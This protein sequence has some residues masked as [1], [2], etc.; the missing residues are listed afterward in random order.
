MK[1]TVWFIIS[2]VCLTTGTMADTWY[3]ATNSVT[4]GPGTA[5]A[6]AFWTIQGGVDAASGG[7]TVLV[8]NG[9][10]NAGGG[11]TPGYTISNRVVLNKA[12]TVRSMTGP[13]NTFIVG[14]GPLGPSAVRCVF[15]TNGASLIGMTLTNG[16]TLSTASETNMSLAGGGALLHYGGMISN[17]IITGCE[18]QKWGGGVSS[19]FGGGEILDSELKYNTVHRQG[20]GIRMEGGGR[21]ERC[22]IHDNLADDWDGGGMYL[23]YEAVVIDCLIANNDGWSGGGIYAARSSNDGVRVYNCTIVG[24]HVEYDGGGIMARQAGTFRNCIIWSNTAELQP[25]TGNYS[26]SGFGVSYQYCCTTPLVLEGTPNITNAPAFTDMASRNYKLL[27]F[28]PCVDS[29]NNDFVIGS[30]DLFGR[31]RIINGTVDMGPYE[32]PV[33]T[34]NIT[35]PVSGSATVTYDVTTYTISGTN[36]EW[37]VGT[38]WWTNSP[39][40]TGGTM[41]ISNLTFEISDITLAVGT[42]TVTVYGTNLFGVVASNSAQIIRGGIGTGTP[43]VDITNDHVSVNYAVT[44]YTLRGT[45]NMHVFGTMWV[46]NAANGE[47]HNFNAS[48][49]WLASPVTLIEGT[50]TLYVW[51]TNLWGV[52]ATDIGNVVR[53]AKQGGDSDVVYYVATNGAHVAPFVTWEYAAT[54]IQPAVDQARDDDRVR[55]GDGVYDAGGAVTPDYNLWN[56]V[57]VTNAVTVESVNGLD[58]TAIVGEDNPAAVNL[59][60]VGATDYVRIENAPG[61]HPVSN[62]TLEAWVYPRSFNFLA[63]FIGKY[64]SASAGGYVLRMS[65]TSPYT[66]V[67]FDGMSTTN[68]VLQADQWY[69]LAAVNS[70]GARHLYV[71]GIEKPVSGTPI[72]IATN[73]DPVTFGVDYLAAPRYLDG[74]MDEVRI[75]NIVRSQT[76]IQGAMNRRLSGEEAGLAGY[77]RLDEGSGTNAVDSTTNGN[78]GVLMNGA[79][80]EA[81]NTAPIQM[82]CVYLAN[83][84][85]LSGFT[86][87]NGHTHHS[88]EISKEGG[89]GGV[90]LN[91]GGVV[92]NCIIT[93]NTAWQQGGGINLHHGGEVWG[94]VVRGN[95][96]DLNGGGV[97]NEGGMM[98]NCLLYN[99]SAHNGG[100]AFFYNQGAA[101]NCTAVSNSAS[102]AGGGLHFYHGGTSVNCIVYNNNAPAGENYT[103]DV[104]G[105]LEYTCTTPDAGGIG[106]ITDDPQFVGGADYRLTTSSPCINKGTNQ[107]WMT[108]ETDLQGYPRILNN[109]VDMGA[110]ENPKPPVVDITNVN[111]TVYYPVTVYTIGGTNAD[112]VTGTM[113]WTNALN[114]SNGTLT[115]ASP[116]SIVDIPIDLGA[117]VISV[118]GSNSY[119]KTDNDNVTITREQK[120][121]P[122][123]PIHYVAT[124][125]GDVWPYTNWT[126]AATIIQDAVNTAA[127]N[128]TVLVSNGVY[129]AGGASTPGYS[130]SNRVCV[131]QPTTVQ[132]VNGPSNTVIV[133]AGPLGASAVRCAYLEGGASLAGFTLTNGHTWALGGSWQYDR[134]GGG[135]W[136]A[137]G[138]MASNCIITG[139]D[140]ATAGGFFLFNGGT[141]SDS[142]I[143][144][145]VTPNEGGG[146]RCEGGGTVQDCLIEENV[147]EDGGG[148]IYLNDGTPLVERCTIR[149]N[150]C[151]VSGADGGGIWFNGAGTVRNCLIAGNRATNCGGGAAFSTTASNTVIENC[152]IVLNTAEDGGGMRMWGGTVRNCIVY[153][154]SGLVVNDNWS[155][156]GNNP[157]IEYTCTT[158]TNNLPGGEGCITNNPRFINAGA[159]DYHLLYGSPC[160][161]SGTDL[162]AVSNDLDGTTRPLDGNY[163]GTNAWDMGCYEYNPAN[164]DSNDDGVPDWWYHGYG[165]N[166]TGTMV[167]TDDDDSDSFDNEQEWIT[168]TDPTNAASYFHVSAVS[169]N[170]PVSVHFDSSSNRQYYLQGS[171]TVITGNWLQITGKTGQ[172]GADAL[173]DTNKPPQGPFYRLGVELP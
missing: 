167:T 63:G 115:A 165:L 99:N 81:G 139:C 85:V 172:G 155:W 97:V 98:A 10:Y 156:G 21:I 9:V 171:T 54:N 15:M 61:L 89:G 130:L 129:A 31:P 133:G 78:N 37:V 34:A 48:S 117:N 18:A 151:S 35:N 86:L 88:G 138:T 162:S 90:F 104:A 76:E 170:S 69:H 46:S 44:A 120:H 28:S 52:T 134:S 135:L 3:V 109:I 14:E 102:N 60:S 144:G 164:A 137:D 112:G 92:S 168:D 142:T 50:N 12:V 95:H 153:D 27:S 82:R 163:D 94:C 64:H 47:V 2:V 17:C 41:G 32:Y 45:N 125:G 73:S 11:L 148:G 1:K 128:D 132:S 25:T 70:N 42:N 159:D 56:R 55:V 100:G 105:T 147:A 80:W 140:A 106:C 22:H 146:G 8:T 40:G 36:S 66:G 57:A 158:P 59:N 29:G 150:Q 118:Y 114:G 68:G 103:I 49:D 16:H 72:T 23:M 143:R 127:S 169:N 101:V 51:G 75:W 154:N 116:W 79:L 93:G 149:N 4:D 123:S 131:T 24:N 111:D 38:M 30:T 113:S 173:Q 65:Q 13:S 145:N 83:D 19:Y 77:W 5:W 74:L 124:N 43:V 157:A 107:A 53:L 33:P 160:I 6:N 110:Y 119:S 58:A 152:T 71:N 20:A 122:G 141:L 87:T 7:D 166:P 62:Y 91:S 84:A 67:G 96:S 26:N 161:D 108:S 39:S 121:G 126:D 136:L